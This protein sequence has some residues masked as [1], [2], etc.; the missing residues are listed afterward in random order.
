MK[1]NVFTRFSR[2]VFGFGLLAALT[3]VPVAQA[4]PF[5]MQNDLQMWQIGSI[6]T[7]I[8]KRI[9]G[10]MDVQNNEVNLTGTKGHSTPGTHYGQLLIRPAIG[11]QVNKYLSVWQGYGWTPSF[12]PQFRN[13]NQIWEQFILERKFEHLHNLSL[14][15]RNRLEIRRIAGAG[16]TA[17]RYR[18]QL[19]AAL[20]LGKTKWSL[21]MYD[22]PF[23]NLNTVG[24]GPR[25]GFNQNWFFFGINRKI[26]KSV[27]AEVG[28]LNNYVNNPLNS[29]DRMNHV[30]M[31]SMN[32]NP[33]FSGIDLRK[34][35]N[36]DEPRPTLDQILQQTAPGAAPPDTPKSDSQ[37]APH[38]TLNA[39]DGTV[40]SADAEAVIAANEAR[41]SLDTPLSVN[42]PELEI[43]PIA[44][45]KPLTDDS[46]ASKTAAPTKVQKI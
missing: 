38:L 42:E 45:E 3:T 18:N 7:H 37:A 11:F 36:I 10:Y 44:N 20:P 30:I 24:N 40:H 35:H 5:V 39:D 46:M 2:R 26:S 29:T 13:E 32:I 17:L 9:L 28:Y 43:L 14:S 25:S 8:T 15:S 23:I 33:T 6:R 31:I 1:N 4:D 19:R 41:A 21:V 16:G 12:Q 27:S 22:E 34:K